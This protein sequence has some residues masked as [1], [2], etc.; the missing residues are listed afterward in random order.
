MRMCGSGGRRANLPDKKENQ[1]GSGFLALTIATTLH[2]LALGQ[3]LTMGFEGSTSI[4]AG[5]KVRL[6]L[7]GA[8]EAVQ[9]DCSIAR[10]GQCSQRFEV[11]SSAQ[12]I[13]HGAPRAEAHTL[14]DHSLHYCPGTV[15]DL[16]FSF[17]LSEGW[18]PATRGMTASI[19]QFKRTESRPDAFVTIRDG[20][21]VLRVGRDYSS[22]ILSEIPRN[23]WLDVS[24]KATWTA[25]SVGALELSIFDPRRRLLGETRYYGQTMLGTSGRGY[26]KWGI[27]KPDWHDRPET[28]SVVWFDDISLRVEKGCV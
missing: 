7:P 22:V 23:E 16:H 6:D 24:L 19:L 15:F 20:R 27:Y 1:R 26:M 14:A 21:L 9:I 5:P 8:P 17:R 11:Y 2:S 3:G 10:T 12:Y 25:T 18:I 13:A 28:M 4:P